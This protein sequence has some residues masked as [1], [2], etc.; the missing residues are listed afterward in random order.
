MLVGALF[1]EAYVNQHY[2][3]NLVKDGILQP[4]WKFELGAE[5]TR[6]ATDFVKSAKI[7]NPLSLSVPGIYT[8]VMETPEATLI[9]FNNATGHPLP[10]LTVRLRE[11]R[12][13]RSVQSTLSDK[14]VYRT[15]NNEVVFDLPLKDA[16]IV[17]LS[18]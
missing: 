12:K 16:D 15:E 1:G 7:S 6:L 11:A 9:F 10:K 2:P 3:Q 17:C 13:I 4:G 14:I 5:T 8:S 18:R